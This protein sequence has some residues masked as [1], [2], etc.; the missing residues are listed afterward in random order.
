VKGTFAHKAAPN[1]EQLGTDISEAIQSY[2]K[3]GLHL[4]DWIGVVDRKH[5]KSIVSDMKKMPKEKR[6]PFYG[7]YAALLKN[8]TNEWFA[9]FHVSP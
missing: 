8:E 5:L 3:K 7:S 1:L 2:Q 6:S 9:T 4:D